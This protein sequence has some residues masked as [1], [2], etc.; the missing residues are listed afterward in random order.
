MPLVERIEVNWKLGKGGCFTSLGEVA[1]STPAPRV[2]C[3]KRTKRVKRL[4]QFQ[5]FALLQKIERAVHRQPCG[6]VAWKPNVSPSAQ[7]V[8][9]Q[10]LCFSLTFVKKVLFLPQISS[11]EKRYYATCVLQWKL[12]REDSTAQVGI[13]LRRGYEDKKRGNSFPMGIQAE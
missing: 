5:A 7:C 10:K 4:E 13:T 1:I 2:T 9:L 6:R 12:E 3:E 11:P 8:R